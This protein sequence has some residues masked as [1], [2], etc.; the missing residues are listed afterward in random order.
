MFIDTGMDKENVV[1]IYNG[2]LISLKK[3]RKFHNMNNMDYD[4]GNKPFR[5]RQ[6]LHDSILGCFEHYLTCPRAGTGGS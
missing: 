1:F 3:I 2:I 6:I 4:K 5:E